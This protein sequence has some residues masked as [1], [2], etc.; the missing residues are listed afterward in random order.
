MGGREL[1]SAS[2]GRMPPMS[3]AVRCGGTVAAVPAAVGQGEA[4]FLGCWQEI[5]PSRFGTSDK[6]RAEAETASHHRDNAA[7]ATGASPLSHVG[8]PPLGP[9]S[10]DRDP[11]GRLWAGIRVVL[12]RRLKNCGRDP[13][14][15]LPIC[16]SPAVRADSIFSNRTVVRRPRSKNRNRNRSRES[17]PG[18]F[19]PGAQKT[20]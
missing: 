7:A 6:R 14:G 16:G 20:N 10:H 8:Q 2:L 17:W 13:D 1:L 4:S 19:G 3:T 15:C 11:A 18:R 5:P 9:S 12:A